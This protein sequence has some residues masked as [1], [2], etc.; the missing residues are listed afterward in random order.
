MVLLSLKQKTGTGYA[1]FIDEELI[2]LPHIVEFLQLKSMP[3]PGT[4]NKFA[5]RIKQSI[6]ELVLLQT[7]ARTGIKKLFLRQDGTG[8]KARKASSYYNFRVKYFQRINK[9]RKRGR[10]KTK[11]KCK[12]YL[13][14][15]IMVELRTQMPLG[16]LITRTPAG[17]AKKF[18]PVAKK[19]IK[20][21]K[22]VKIVCLDKGYD[23]EKVH[24]FIREIMEALLIIPARNQDVPIHRT[25]GKYR[26]QMKR[27]YSRK[28]I[29]HEKQK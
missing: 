29:F 20:L 11:L 18:S 1:T 22:S 9:K 4:L 26:K 6:L 21:G 15:Q 23:D 13:Y 10:P 19:V 8:F 5:I 16:V 7:T 17:D 12:K 27:K 14:V 3:R 24:E 25:H 2:E 28:K